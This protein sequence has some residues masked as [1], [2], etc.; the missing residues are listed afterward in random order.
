M[1]S[2][3]GLYDVALHPRGQFDAGVSSE[4]L[5]DGELLRVVVSGGGAAVTPGV[6]VA[7]FAGLAPTAQTPRNVT[8]GLGSATFAG[9]APTVQTPRTMFPGLGLA[10]FTGFAPA[11]GLAVF[12]G[13]GQ[14]TFAG[15]A[16]TIVALRSVVVQQVSDFRRLLRFRHFSN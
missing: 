6:G 1:A 13:L 15:Y 14:A 9:V 8:P 3:P 11:V 12:P 4:G 16:P 7:V 2:R 10:I 5:F